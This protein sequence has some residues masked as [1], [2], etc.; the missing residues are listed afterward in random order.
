L[1]RSPGGGRGYPLQYSC[2]DNPR[3]RG[4][5]WATV[6]GVAESW[7]RLKRVSTQALAPEPGASRTETGFKHGCIQESNWFDRNLFCPCLGLAS[8]P[9]E[10]GLC[11]WQP[12]AHRAPVDN[13][14]KSS[15][16]PTQPARASGPTQIALPGITGP[17]PEPGSWDYFTDPGLGYQR[18]PCSVANTTHKAKTPFGEGAALTE[19]LAK[20]VSPECA[21]GSQGRLH[22]GQAA[23]IPRRSHTEL[24]REPARSLVGVHP[25]R[26][27]S[28]DSNQCVWTCAHGCSVSM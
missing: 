23:H 5:W 2:L 17:S 16:F 11:S 26:T 28:K 27:E 9:L 4:A 7:T 3:D 8:L 15:S 1:G 6:P 13:K 10:L 20:L 14:Q 21:W 24:P 19:G 22:R 12:W 25:K 18:K